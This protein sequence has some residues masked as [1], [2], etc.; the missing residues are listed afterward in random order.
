MEG[1][2]PAGAPSPSEAGAGRLLGGRYRLLERLGA[3]GMGTVWRARDEVVDRDVAVKEPRVPEIAERWKREH[4]S[5]SP[6]AGG[7]PG[8]ATV[9]STTQQGRDAAVITETYSRQEG[10]DVTR[11]LYKTLVVT[12]RQ[13]RVT[14]GVDVPDGK[15]AAKTAG[16][17]LEKARSG[18]EIRN[19]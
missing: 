15:S 6:P 1:S 7:A 2:R 10:D 3:G 9:E 11:R 18:F 5:A 19:P 16:D 8:V 13:E 14:P 17:L 12:T 4:E